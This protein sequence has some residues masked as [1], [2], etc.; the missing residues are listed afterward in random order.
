MKN[1][2]IVGQRIEIAKLF[3]LLM[4]Q[5]NRRFVSAKSLTQCLDLATRTLPALIIIDCEIADARAC[6][7][8]VAAL[9]DAPDTSKTPVFLIDDPQQGDPE[10]KQLLG[11]ADGIFSEPFNPTEIKTIAEQSL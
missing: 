1:V 6:H 9:K 2:L 7:E 10:T 11:L 3:E 8:T 4:Q 5:Q